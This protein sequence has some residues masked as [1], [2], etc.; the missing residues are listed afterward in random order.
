MEGEA[1]HPRARNF[2]FANVRLKDVT[3]LAQ[4]TEV[5][6]ENPL[7]GLSLTKISGNCRTGISL[8]H[9][10]DVELRDID[11]TGF[12]G[13]LLS[14][15]DVKGIGLEGAVLYVAPTPGRPTPTPQAH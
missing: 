1:G 10:R 8:A 6:A 3:T 13:P 5:A 14:T 15:D 12:E 2:R 9:V 11:V 4:V 7:L